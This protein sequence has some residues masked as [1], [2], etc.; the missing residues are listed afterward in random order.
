MPVPISYVTIGLHRIEKINPSGASIIS[1]KP[2]REIREVVGKEMQLFQAR[3]KSQS[4]DILY[5][6]LPFVLFIPFPRKGQIYPTKVPPGSIQHD[7]GTLETSYEVVV[8]VQVGQT[9]LK[10]KSFPVTLFRYDLLSTFRMYDWPETQEKMSDHLV[11]LGLVLPRWSFGP[12]DPVAI[13]VRVTPNPDYMKRAKKVTIKSIILGIDEEITFNPESDIPT[14]KVRQL[15]EKKE[16]VMQKL[17]EEGFLTTLTMTYPN[18]D[19]RDSDGFI[20]NPETQAF[21]SLWC[22]GFTTTA[23]LYK[24]EYYVTVKVRMPLVFP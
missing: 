4:D 24:I 15:T 9:E 11:T 16:R 5:M 19:I 1:N 14:T 8:S 12:E 20:Q 6:D 7:T 2:K 13:Q 17:M 22:S 10:K 3:G 23:T 18:K 21:P